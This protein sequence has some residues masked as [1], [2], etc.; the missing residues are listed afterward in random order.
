MIILTKITETLIICIF[1]P[2]FLSVVFRSI[3]TQGPDQQEE[4]HSCDQ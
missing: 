1:S 3:N 4:E 2:K